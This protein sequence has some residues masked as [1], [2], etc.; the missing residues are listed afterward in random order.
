MLWR[1]VCK[2]S[3]DLLTTPSRKL[4]SALSDIDMITYISPLVVHIY[5][6]G[7]EQW[8]SNIFEKERKIQI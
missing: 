2:I 7:Q 5:Q 3:I 8:C 1:G 4:K 6:K